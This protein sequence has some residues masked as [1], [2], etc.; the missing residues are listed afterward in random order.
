MNVK[1]NDGDLTDLTYHHYTWKNI[2][3]QYEAIF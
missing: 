2:I 3:K 1:Q